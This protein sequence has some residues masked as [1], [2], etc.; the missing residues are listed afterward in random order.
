[1]ARL[2]DPHAQRIYAAAERFIN[3]ALR[4]DDSLFTPG[5]KIWTA[6]TIDEL[7]RHF[8]LHPDEG[9]GDF[10]S[11]LKGQ[12]AGASAQTYQLAAEVLYIHFLPASRSV[13]TGPIKRAK[14]Q[15]VLDWSPEPGTLIPQ[16]LATTLDEGL[17]AMGTAYHIFRWRLFEF[18]IEF[19]RA[20][21]A[22]SAQEQERLLDDPWAFKAMLF[23]VP[24]KSAYSQREI[25]LHLIHPDTF[26]A[27]ASRDH[28]Q[29]IERA[30]ARYVTEPSS[31]IDRRIAQIRQRLAREYGSDF[32]FYW[33][34]IYNIWINGGRLV[35]PAPPPFD[36]LGPDLRSYIRLALRLSDPSYTPEEMVELLGRINPPIAELRSAPDPD[37]LVTDLSLL[38]LLEPLDNGRYR[39]WPHLADATE[40]HMLR[41][42]ALTLAL[43][44]EGEDTSYVLPIEQVPQDGGVHAA[45]EWP[46]GEPLLTWYEQAELVQRVGDGWQLRPDALDPLDA[47]TPT[48]QAINI[49]LGNLRRVWRSKA[50][51]LGLES[52]GLPVLDLATLDA[53]IAEIQRDLLIDRP[54]ILR[55]YRSLIAG[56]HVI[57]SGPPGTGKTHLAR[58]LPRIL[59]RDESTVWLAMPV[60]PEQSPTDEPQPTPIVQQGYAVE[61]V[62][63]TEDWGTRHVIGGIVPQLEQNGNGRSLVYGV[64]HG[65]LTRTVLQNYGGDGET[66]PET[67]STTR[68]PI[69]I[70]AEQYR[71]RWLVIDEFTRAP[72]DAAFGSLL[73][74]L[75]GQSNPKLAVPTDAGIDRDIPLPS[76]FR[77]IGTLNSFDRHFLNQISEAMKRRFT[78]ID[79][80]PPSRGLGTTEQAMAIY[81]ALLSLQ[82]NYLSNISADERA[83]RANWTGVLSVHREET[84][85]DAL[86]RVRYLLDVAEPE[87]RA[88]IDSFWRLFEAIR[89]YRQLGTAQAEAVYA[90][91]F[92]GRSIGMTWPEA[93]DSALADVLADQLQVL[94][95]DEQR[96]LAALIEHHDNIDAFTDAVKHIL[97]FMPGP[98]QMA[99]LAQLRNAD[100]A[101]AR[102]IDGTDASKLQTA[103]L[104]DLFRF[105][106]P[107][108][109]PQPGL[110]VR[111]MYAFINEKG[112]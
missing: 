73:T 25:L 101:T 27:I 107:L 51:T 14:L 95:R 69:T 56:R 12:L 39:R 19:A 44:V 33:E 4:H 10:W 17:A 108:D 87:A 7:H 42:A 89:V 41:Y 90:T 38:R 62:T 60:R 92:A 58:I 105:D 53:R 35:D 104:S 52:N 102:S 43:P 21:K 55:I 48:A 99:H 9:G 30:F 13:M 68:Q 46:G 79:V 20:W 6:A 85:D 80:L 61:V 8:V 110:F 57:L 66:I 100:V 82:A 77:L 3:G 45:A 111:R 18:L 93:L 40:T 65:V 75:G 23:A 31:D 32:H 29:K 96:V 24:M 26:E 34:D 86:T 50:T 88:A 47:T 71:G 1:M 36:A 106:V 37:N 11:K 84:P 109:L 5:R 78:F 22:L 76:D 59:W 91:I 103:Q 97:R 16:D 67:M 81:R 54:T 2:S 70:G 49:F 63:A 98:R 83:G 72:I 28:K 74:T 64:R 15:Q 112:L 94:A